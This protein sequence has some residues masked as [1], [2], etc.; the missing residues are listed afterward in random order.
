MDTYVDHGRTGLLV[1]PD[2]PAAMADAIGA[3]LSDPER[4]AEMG[5][6]GRKEVEARFTSAHMAREL[7]AIVRG[8]V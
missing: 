6:A 4:A 3:L 8:V 2:D 1:P 5:E 7:R